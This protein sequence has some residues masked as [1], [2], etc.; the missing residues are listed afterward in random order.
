MALNLLAIFVALAVAAFLARVPSER[1]RWMDGLLRLLDHRVTPPVVGIACA[2]VPLLAWRAAGFTPIDHDEV[3]YLLQAHIFAM[4]R[5][6]S[7]PP[8]MPAFFGQAHVLVTP[9]LASKYPPGHSLLLAL[10][11]LAG[12]PVAVVF[13]L[14]VVR[15]GLTFALARRLSD[16]GTAL[17]TVLVLLLG[18]DPRRFASSYYS[19]LTSGAALLVCWYCLWKWRDAGRRSWLLGAAASLGWIAITRP[20]SA[21]A[22]AVP[23][24]VIVLRHIWRRRA[25]TDLALAMGFGACV[26]A[27]IPLWAHGTLGDWRRTPQLEYTRDYMPFDFPHFGTVATQ[28][29]LVPPPDVAAVNLSL[30]AVEREHTVGNLGRQAV[31]RAE[32][33]FENVF[34]D[35]VLFFA[36]AMVVGLVVMPSA[37]W[38]GVWTLVATFVGY[39]AHPTW[40]SWT[41]YYLEVEPV[42]VFAAALGLSAIWRKLAG[43]WRR[44]AWNPAPRAMIAALVGCLCLAPAIV[45]A[46]SQVRN[47]LLNA[48]VERRAFQT[49][50]AGLPHKPAVVFVL[51]GPNHSPHMSLTGNSADWPH[52]PVWVV[53]DLGPQSEALIRAAPGRH[54]YVYDEGRQQ[55]VDLMQ[56]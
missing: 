1:L 48:T 43:E 50:V 38:F 21:L 27:V 14:N 17:L 25:F 44:E 2:L 19:E 47:G 34:P 15:F 20:W 31:E 12:A 33:L 28:P 29:R 5:W 9:V 6:A 32:A 26:V 22:F 46:T 55:F 40:S 10:G 45:D 35:P 42:L 41:V 56:Q 24:A 7:P 4:G 23:I 11:A 51:Y 18:K 16:G 3:A 37:G 54:P 13:L 52:A 30:R 8:P 39:L 53:Y 36:A 49:A